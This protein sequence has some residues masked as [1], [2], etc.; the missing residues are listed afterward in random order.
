MPIKRIDGVRIIL[1]HVRSS[2]Q[3]IKR[4]QDEVFKSDDDEDFK[5]IINELY[6]KF[7]LK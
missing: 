3:L 5:F 7:Q 4:T 6:E 2:A 1:K